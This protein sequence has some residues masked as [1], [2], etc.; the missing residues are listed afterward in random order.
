M[1]ASIAT[2]EDFH[3]T[4][5]PES[6]RLLS[7]TQSEGDRTERT[8]ETASNVESGDGE[9]ETDTFLTSAERNDNNS[10]HSVSEFRTLHSE[11]YVSR[12][13]IAI[14]MLELQTRENSRTEI[15]RSDNGENLPTEETDFGNDA[16]L[17]PAMPTKTDPIREQEYEVMASFDHYRSSIYNDSERGSQNIFRYEEENRYPTVI[18]KGGGGI[19]GGSSSGSSSRFQTLVNSERFRID[20]P[21]EEARE[22]VNLPSPLSS[23][24][25]NPASNYSQ[26]LTAPKLPYLP[27]EVITAFDYSPPSS[28]PPAPP[29][30]RTSTQGT[31]SSKGTDHFLDGYPSLESTRASFDLFGSLSDILVPVPF[32]HRDLVRPSGPIARLKRPSQDSE[33]SSFIASGSDYDSSQFSSA[34]SSRHNSFGQESLSKP[35]PVPPKS[36][37]KRLPSIDA[38]LSSGRHDPSILDRIVLS[39]SPQASL[40]VPP[41]PPKPGKHSQHIFWIGAICGE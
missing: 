28:P 34:A 23:I 31:L 2:R 40:N 1:S 7:N 6:Q 13:D 9:Q 32:T 18:R 36:A 3:G 15:D 8:S 12:E 26:R 35:P 5:T 37:D 39:S 19:G 27:N 24:S 30:H 38:L 33:T 29:M 4:H 16:L 21:P 17:H 25:S 20:L 22:Y 14:E 41:I 10:R 11:L